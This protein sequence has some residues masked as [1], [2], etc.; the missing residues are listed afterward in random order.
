MSCLDL[1]RLFLAVAEQRSFT[2]AARRLNIS[3]TAVSKGVRALE[4]KHDVTLFTRT[5]R[6]V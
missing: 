2:L 6:S 4:R 3:P 1:I 5:T